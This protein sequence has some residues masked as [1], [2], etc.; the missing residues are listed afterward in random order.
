MPVR[1]ELNLGNFDVKDFGQSSRATYVPSVHRDTVSDHSHYNHALPVNRGDQHARRTRSKE[2]SLHTIP[3]KPLPS[4]RPHSVP[5]V[6]ERHRRP[7]SSS[8]NPPLRQHLERS[9]SRIL[10]YHKHNPYYG[11]TNFSP[12][13]VKYQEKFQ[14]YRDD[15]AEHIRLCSP[16]PSVAF[17]EA[18]RLS[19][20]VRSD[21]RVV[22]IKMMDEVIYHK[23]TQHYSLME[24]LLGT[25]DAELVEDSDKDWFWGIGADGKGFNEL[26]KA[27]ERLRTRLRRERWPCASTSGSGATVLESESHVRKRSNPSAVGIVQAQAPLPAKPLSSAAP[28]ISDKRIRRQSAPIN[29]L[30]KV[31][32]PIL[33]YTSSDE[34]LHL[35]SIVIR[36]RDLGIIASVRERV[37]ALREIS[38]TLVYSVPGNF[39]ATYPLSPFPISIATTG[40]ST[41]TLIIAVNAVDRSRRRMLLRRNE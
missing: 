17:S 9:N 10:F 6:L 23:F 32:A 27:L 31:S 15:L 4:R 25:G 30:C 41:K 37:L 36:N 7:Q 26:G 11:F 22:N 24:E 8:S 20:H 40:R 38:A 3:T 16:Y 1:A 34:A 12:H 5:P 21:W 18:R 13:N 35:E 19:D 39:A 14:G 29:E 2:R 33:H 28:I